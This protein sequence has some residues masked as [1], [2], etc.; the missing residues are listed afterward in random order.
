[1]PISNRLF[2]EQTEIVELEKAP[3]S[4]SLISWHIMASSSFIFGRK[5]ILHSQLYPPNV[6]TH[7]ASFEHGFVSHLNGV[8]LLADQ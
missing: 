8:S 1:M 7:S 5:P 3:D 2:D 4:H 6:L